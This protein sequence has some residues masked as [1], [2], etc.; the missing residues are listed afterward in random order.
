[1]F[2]STPDVEIL[3]HVPNS[4]VYVWLKAANYCTAYAGAAV[5]PTNLVPRPVSFLN[6]YFCQWLNPSPCS[7]DSVMAFYSS[8]VYAATGSA[9][10]AAVAAAVSAAVAAA[11]AAFIMCDCHYV[12]RLLSCCHLGQ[13]WRKFWSMRS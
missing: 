3:L 8:L 4:V 6:Q 13:V 11:A 5:R 9:A 7:W 10:A 12:V 2:A 1:M